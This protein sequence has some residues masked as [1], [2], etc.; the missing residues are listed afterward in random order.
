MRLTSRLP[1]RTLASR[2]AS[3]RRTSARKATRRRSPREVS[4]SLSQS[5]LQKASTRPPS[6]EAQRLPTSSN[7]QFLV[8]TNESRLVPFTTRKADLSAAP[9]RSASA[10]LPGQR[11][12]AQV[13]PLL[14]QSKTEKSILTTRRRAPHPP[15]PATKSSASGARRTRSRARRRRREI[16]K[17][18]GTRANMT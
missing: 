9:P 1:A 14:S 2:R 4:T 5:G 13:Q 3:L 11:S 17:A 10:A 15:V 8:I 18:K 7:I 6:R 16:S 12:P